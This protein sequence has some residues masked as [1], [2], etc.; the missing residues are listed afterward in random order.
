MYYLL[1]YEA[2][3]DYVNVRAPYRESHLAHAREAHDRGELVLGGAFADPPD[4]AVLVFRADAKET[5]ESF[6]RADPYV[7]NGAIK[8]WKVREWTVVIGEE[9]DR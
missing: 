9:G 2:A 5:V 7:V 1:F 3:D 6:A 8:S 4:G